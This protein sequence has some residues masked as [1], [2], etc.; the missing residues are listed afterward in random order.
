MRRT[1]HS[2]RRPCVGLALSLLL[3]AIA[4]LC[5]THVAATHLGDE[6]AWFIFLPYIGKKYAYAP[7]T[8]VP[9]TPTSTPT[10]TPT[11]TPTSTSTPIVTSTPTS[12]STPTATST[13]TPT[14]TPTVSPTSSFRP[15]QGSWSGRESQK[16]YPVSFRVTAQQTVKDFEIKVPFGWGYTCEIEVLVELPIV[17]N[18]FEFSWFGGS[19][20]GHFTSNSSADGTY[21]VFYCGGQ[22]QVPASEGTWQ[23]H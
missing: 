1:A 3:V 16:G 21:S 18:R 6:S 2:S 8:P 13:S 11:E 17:N 22:V 9:P 7:P 19:I 12:T 5:N 14:P 20:T 4:L 10:S 15:R 23:A